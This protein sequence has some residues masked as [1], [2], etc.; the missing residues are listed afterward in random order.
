LDAPQEFGQFANVGKATTKPM[1]LIA[2]VLTQSASAIR[3]TGDEFLRYGYYYNAQWEFNGNW[4]LGKYFTYWKLADFWVK[5]LNIPDMY[6]DKLRFFL[7]GGV[8]VWR[9]PEDI[10]N[11]TIYEN[12]EV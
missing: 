6:V 12:M 4:N 9:N 3:Q 2:N 8:T 1:A 5:G 7:Y 10:G 11:R